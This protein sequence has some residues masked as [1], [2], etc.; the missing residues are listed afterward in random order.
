[1]REHKVQRLPRNLHS[2][3]HKVLCLARN[4]HFE[5]RKVLCLPRNL[6]FQIHK[7]LRL[8]RNLHFEV[9]KVLCLP[10]NLHFEVR[11]VL[12]LPRNLHFQVHKVQNAE[13]ATKSALQCKATTIPCNCHEKSP[14]NY[15]NTRFPLRKSHH[16]VRPWHHNKSAVA[17]ST[18]RG[19]PD[20]ATLRSRNALRGFREA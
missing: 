9:H 4:L 7:V 8:P 14:L 3:A 2:E 16:H 10:R 13:P 18:C 6:H 11:K 12:C 20:S 5:V 1:M 15:Q 19:H 17:T